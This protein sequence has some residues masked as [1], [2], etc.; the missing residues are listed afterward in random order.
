VKAMAKRLRF[1]DAVKAIQTTPKTLRNWLQ[2]DQI[3]LY[4]S[5]SG[6]AEYRLEDIAV[7][8]L[9]K[10]L[11]DFG[12]TVRLANSLAE[13]AMFEYPM[14]FPPRRRQELS[15][16]QYVKAW[17]NHRLHVFRDALVEEGWDLEPVYKNNRPEHQAPAFISIDVGTVL[18]KVFA[19]ALED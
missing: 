8:A 5:N 17:A 19:R 2:R 4:W 16:I 7:L 13:R 15:P 11:V 18:E 3:K 10:T 6:W 1:A 14:P 12:I 9:T